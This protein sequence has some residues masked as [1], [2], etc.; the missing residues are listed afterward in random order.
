MCHI[1]SYQIASHW[2]DLLLYNSIDNK[3]WNLV[4]PLNHLH[5]PVRKE[6]TEALLTIEGVFC[7]QLDNDCCETSET[8]EMTAV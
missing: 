1:G 5:S 2:G 8:C 7:L 3:A 6:Y 4:L